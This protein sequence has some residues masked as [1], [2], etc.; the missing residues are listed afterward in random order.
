M[1]IQLPQFKSHPGACSPHTKHCV[2]CR[3]P[4]LNF[5]RLEETG[6]E[7]FD[8]PHGLPVGFIQTPM[9]VKSAII[10]TAR[11]MKSI[12]STAIGVNVAPKEQQDDRLG[13]CTNCPSGVAKFDK[14]G[15]LYTCGIM[16]DV[17]R[18]R[19]EA[20]C[21]CVLSLK[22]ADKTQSCPFNHWDEV[23]KKHEQ[24]NNRNGDI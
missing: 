21:G 9:E 18:A 1:N 13:V 14:N 19:G 22:T 6:K 16:I 4:N 3:N 15:K 10:N 8:C 11:A 24:T 5:W 12:I 7:E 23:D 20:P 2:Y 17:L